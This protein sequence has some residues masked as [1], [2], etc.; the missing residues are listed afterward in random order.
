M[1]SRAREGVDRDAQPSALRE[2]AIER[3]SR[4][5]LLLI[6]GLSIDLNGVDT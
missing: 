6:R 2:N 3:G 5:G 4:Q 1:K